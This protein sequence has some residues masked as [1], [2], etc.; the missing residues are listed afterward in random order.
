MRKVPAENVTCADAQGRPVKHNDPQARRPARHVFIPS[1]GAG[2]PLEEYVM[3]SVPLPAHS[4]RQ[5]GDLTTLSTLET[6]ILTG[7]ICAGIWVLIGVT[8][9]GTL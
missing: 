3:P 5:R 2:G 4:K 8:I 1:R 9:V 6:L 7:Q